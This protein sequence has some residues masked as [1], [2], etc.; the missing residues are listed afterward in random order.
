MVLQIFSKDYI[1]S[2]LDILFKDMSED[3]KKLEGEEKDE[4]WE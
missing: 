4:E 1:F 2:L 3:Y